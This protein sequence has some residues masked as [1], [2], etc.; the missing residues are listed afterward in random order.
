MLRDAIWPS[1]GKAASN[2]WEEAGRNL[3]LTHL[4]KVRLLLL[5]GAKLGSNFC[6]RAEGVCEWF[7][8]YLPLQI[9]ECHLW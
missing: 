9:R 7:D 4:V 6:G 5:L 3:L 2:T 8:S 1:V